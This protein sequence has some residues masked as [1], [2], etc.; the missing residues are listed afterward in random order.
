MIKKI[1]DIKF[2][3][4]TIIATFFGIGNIKYASGT[5]GS[6][7]TLP[8]FILISYFFTKLKSFVSCIILCVSIIIILFCIGYWAVD[9]YIKTNNSKDP[10][11]VVIDE[12]IGQMIAYI[13]S[14]IALL[15]FASYFG[16]DFS[17]IGNFETAISLIL[18][19]APFIFFRV[20]D[21]LKPG[22]VGYFDKKV[23]GA[24]GII[25]DDVI[26]GFYSGFVVSFIL[27]ILFYLR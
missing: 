19:I 18:L 20:F 13:L 5:F 10:K 23:E 21:I 25:L 9:L 17:I 1:K 12:V 14:T 16:N 4:A 2:Q 11:E 8:F 6:M 7:V 24:K 3:L 26:A 22:L 15:F 27:F